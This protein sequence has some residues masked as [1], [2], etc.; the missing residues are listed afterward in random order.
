M[1]IVVIGAS[2]NVG[3]SVLRALGTGRRPAGAS[4]LE[5][6]AVARRVPAGGNEEG[7][8]WVRADITTDDLHPIVDGADVV[9][10]LAWAIQPSRDERV[11]R[12][13]NIE[14]SHRV[15]DAA[16][17]G[18]VG[19]VVYASSVGAYSAGPEDRAVD[20]TW[21]THGI[22]TSTYSRHKAYVERMLD[23]FRAENPDIRVVRLRPGLIFKKGAAS[24]IRR[25]FLGPFVPSPLLRKN[26]IPV[27]PD[28]A[29]LAFQAVHSLDVGEAYR[30][31]ALSDVSGAFNIAA[32]PV[33]T[34][35][36]LAEALD[37]HP[38]R[39]S[40][41]LLRQAAGL[42]WWLRLQPTPPGWL[43]LAME[44]PVMDTSRAGDLLG[45][46]PAHTSVDAV[47]ELLEGLSGDAGE[48]APPLASTAGGRLRG[49]E[50]RTGVGKTQGT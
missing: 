40:S 39:V 47:G 29:G 23:T 41:S 17:R 20:E 2:G 12:A 33:L 30:L 42:T 46:T 37:A 1:R 32:D 5:V 43:D 44:S 6:V 45:W 49:H 14:G 11:L 10:H 34:T 35:R 3:T 16:A 18:G 19:A 38:V 21:P 28:I 9:I 36:R 24:E 50:L 8:S 22:A 31:A 13:T 26:L 48:E 4:P 7:V 25:L 27:V 15:F